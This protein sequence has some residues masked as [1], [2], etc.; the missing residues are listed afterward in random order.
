MNEVLKIFVILGVVLFI[1]AGV[2]TLMFLFSGIFLSGDTI[3]VIDM[4]GDIAENGQINAALMNEMFKD[5]ADDP[6]V[7]A[8]ILRINSGGGAVVETKEIARSLSA[9]SSEKPV[10]AYISEVGASGAYYV[11]AHA[12]FI[13]ADEDSLVGSIGVIST[14]T[15]YQ[16]LLEDK[17]GI[18]TT[19]LK[20]GKFKDIGSPYRDMTEEEKQNLQAIV[21]TVHSEFMDVIVSNRGLTRQAIS[22]VNTSNI[23]LGSKALQ[24]GLVD[25]NGGFDTA[26]AIAQQASDSPDA[27]PKY[28]S[29]SDYQDADLYYS[30]GRGVGDS[31]ASKIDLSKGQLEFK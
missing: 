5:A 2:A 17:L 3:A 7:V 16:N 27:E 12:D 4:S 31:L 19:V 15:S 11:A 28:L 30:I 22:E 9:L 1:L 14:Y 8:V 23:F 21:D 26:L 10:V 13:V 20:S 24:L 18:N 25:Y 29:S 6:S